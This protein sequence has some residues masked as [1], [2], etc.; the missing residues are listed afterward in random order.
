[1]AAANDFALAVDV[2]NEAAAL[3]LDYFI[4]GATATDKADGTIVT[5]AD[6]AVE[7]Q[8]RRQLTL[9][10]RNDGIL[11]EE[12]GQTGPSHRRWIIDP[13]DGTSD[14]VTGASDWR[15][16][17]A[18][19]I[20][21]EVT[22]AVVIA[23]SQGRTWVAEAG[24]GASVAAWPSDGTAPTRLSVSSTTVW[25]PDRI[26]AWP[27][28]GRPAPIGTRTTLPTSVVPVGVG[29]GILDA[30][31]IECCHP[32]D[33]APW[34]LITEEA[35]GRFTDWAGGRSAHHRG[36]VFSNAVLHRELVDALGIHISS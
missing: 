10:A 19:E 2:A 3:A 34:I 33:H 14:F 31:V 1:M 4:K 11:G 16:Q 24:G 21:G 20:A 9:D 23:P 27:L 36:G 8:I 32:W 7:K 13:I 18:L 35:N 12:Y 15:V 26:S 28:D 25:D 6:F 22:V 29:T 17:L 5:E 30:F